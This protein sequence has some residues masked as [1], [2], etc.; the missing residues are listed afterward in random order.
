MNIYLLRQLIPEGG[1]LSK[2][3]LIQN[4]HPGAPPSETGI[5]WVRGTRNLHFYKHPE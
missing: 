3:M 2:V 5:Q 4:A 1:H